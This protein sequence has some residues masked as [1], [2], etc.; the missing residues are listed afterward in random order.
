[1]STI[2][3][4]LVEVEP[5]PGCEL[6]PADTKG[7]FA[8]CYTPAADAATAETMI[9]KELEGQKLHVVQVDW[10]EAADGTEWENPEDEDAAA[11]IQEAEAT[12]E[13]VI[14]RLDTWNDDEDEG[15]A[16]DDEIQA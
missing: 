14:G 3:V 9:T 13:V 4:A 7:G 5:R 11:C 2:Y 8:R 15:D 1:M 12:G 6:C 16:P 10:C